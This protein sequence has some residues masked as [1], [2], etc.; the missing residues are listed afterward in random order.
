MA[1]TFGYTPTQKV[2]RGGIL[3]IA[4]WS[5]STPPADGDFV[6]IGECSKLDIAPK[7]TSVKSY[8]VQHGLKEVDAVDPVAVENTVTFVLE[9]E[10]QDILALFVL[11]TKVGSNEVTAFT[12]LSQEWAL[13]FIPAV[14]RGEGWIEK[15]W[16]VRITPA[17]A[18]SLLSPDKYGQVNFTAEVMADYSNNPT[19]PWGDCVKMTS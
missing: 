9:Q 1:I 13:K 11:G 15:I 5:G 2:I 6:N 4:A 12:N 18:R 16:R 3:Y 10:N 7:V 17:G 8:T 19:K 14:V